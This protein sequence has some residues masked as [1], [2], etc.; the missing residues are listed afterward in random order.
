MSNWM[1]S[2]TE[3]DFHAK[4]NRLWKLT[5]TLKKM[6]KTTTKECERTCTGKWKHFVQWHLLAR[7]KCF[8]SLFVC[9]YTIANQ[10]EINKFCFVKTKLYGLESVQSLSQIS[11]GPMMSWPGINLHIQRLFQCLHC[12]FSLYSLSNWPFTKPLPQTAIVQL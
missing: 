7:A 1:I 12:I 11:N 5:Q 6:T 8:N 4:M 3:N 10:G 2:C 9:S